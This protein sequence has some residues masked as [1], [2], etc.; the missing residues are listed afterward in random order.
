MTRRF[1][2]T[3]GHAFEVARD[4]G[5]FL[6]G[7]LKAMR[8]VASVREVE[9]KDAVVGFEEGCVDLCIVRYLN[10]AISKS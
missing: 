2:E 8:E 5:Y 9:G 4:H 10:D 6:G 1:I 3:V 7:G